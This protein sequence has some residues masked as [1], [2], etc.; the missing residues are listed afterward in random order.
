MHEKI[1]IPQNWLH[2]NLY[3]KKEFKNYMELLLLE[4]ADK[5]QH[6]YIKDF[7]RFMYNKTKYKEKSIFV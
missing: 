6:V 1:K 5:S 4:N 3:T 7:N 2:I